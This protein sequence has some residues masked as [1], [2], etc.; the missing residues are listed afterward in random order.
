MNNTAM[1]RERRVAR[2][3]LRHQHGRTLVE[4]MIGMVIGLMVLG[5]VMRT[6]VSTSVS[7]RTQDNL[8]K[9]SEDA[10][11]ALNLVA[12]HVRMAGF[13]TPRINTTPG[14]AS[15]N[16]TGAPMRG[17]DGAIND[18]TAPMQNIICGAANQ[19]NMFS[20]AYEADLA[21]TLAINGI[22][23]D[24]LGQDL[25]PQVS[26]FTGNFFVAENRFFI[27]NGANGEPELACAGNGG[28]NGFN[29]PQTLIENVEDMR[30][31]YG[32]SNTSVTEWGNTVFAGRV[33]NYL[34]ADQLDINFAAEDVMTRWNRI[35]AVWICMQLR[36][37]DGV[38][39]EPTP[40]TDCTGNVVV[41]PDR[42][43]RIA[44]TTTVSLRNRTL[45]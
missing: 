39:N 2:T 35:S 1:R 4:I 23:S 43:L 34:T 7:S 9:L 15:S 21:N 10:Q 8:G 41:P 31:T 25:P 44:V 12:D 13:S 42:R 17:C 28:L 45:P 20:V 30:L 5:T 24:C 37:N 32:I 6:V 29:A 33:S 14:T 38:A 22:P 11:I 16:Y 18:L 27:R 19:P 3:A 26:P 40:Y 36:T